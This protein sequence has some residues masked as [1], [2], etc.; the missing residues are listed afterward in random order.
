MIID[1][2]LEDL[3]KKKDKKR[4]KRKKKKKES[5]LVVVDAPIKEERIRIRNFGTAI[6]EETKRWIYDNRRTLKKNAP[7]IENIMAIQLTK[8]NIKY[9]QQCPFVFPHNYI[10]FADF[11]LP[12]QTVVVEVDGPYHRCVDRQAKDL[13]RDWKFQEQC[14][15]TIRI[16]NS[17]VGT[18]RNP[19][20][21]LDIIKQKAGIK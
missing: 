20:C 14:I 13:I 18:L 12:I 8:A 1:P 5:I 10:Y 7:I 15:K 6:K 16:K 11:Y 19:G 3:K 21:A 9:I 17:E 4:R 2:R